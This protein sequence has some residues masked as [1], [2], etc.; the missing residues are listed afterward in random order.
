MLQPTIAIDDTECSPSYELQNGTEYNFSTR[1]GDSDRG[2][3]ASIE[4]FAG[5]A[6]RVELA[7]SVNLFGVED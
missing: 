4:N 6:D 5:D 7:N 1:V 3:F 2:S